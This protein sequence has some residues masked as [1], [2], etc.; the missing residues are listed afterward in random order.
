MVSFKRKRSVLNKLYQLTKKAEI[1]TR[2]E[3]TTVGI[4]ISYEL[5]KETKRA[6]ARVA[7]QLRCK[8]NSEPK[9]KAECA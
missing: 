4:D 7:S 9:K 1:L 2:K 3:Y 5:R 6:Q 8:A